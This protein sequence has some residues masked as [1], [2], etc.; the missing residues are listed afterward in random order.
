MMRNKYAGPCF[1][2]TKTVEAGTGHFQRL[3]G[4][5]IVQH[6]ECAIEHRGTDY[7]M[8]D[9]QKAGRKAD[10]KRQ[11]DATIARWKSRAQGTGKAAKR[12]RRNLRDA[13]IKIE[14]EQSS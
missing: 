3:N 12:A 13:G 5:W 9:A 10:K 7:G 2:C 1:R 8:T 14:A 6:A 4:S 11:R